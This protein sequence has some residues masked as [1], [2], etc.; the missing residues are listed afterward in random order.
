MVRIHQRAPSKYQRNNNLHPALR[1]AL[2]VDGLPGCIRGANGSGER[3]FAIRFDGSR[4]GP[5]DQVTKMSAVLL[6]TA[7]PV[8]RTAAAIYVWATQSG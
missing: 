2:G 4:R 6:E 7:W 8:T 3:P 1:A 5:I